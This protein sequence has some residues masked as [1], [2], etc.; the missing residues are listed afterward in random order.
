MNL[1]TRRPRFNLNA[2]LASKKKCG[3]HKRVW[4]TPR[5]TANA[6]LSNSAFY[7]KRRSEQL[8]TPLQT[9][10]WGTPHLTSN[11]SLSNFASCFKRKFEKLCVP[12]QTGVWE[13]LRLM[14]NASLSNSAYYFK[15]RSEQLCSPLQMQVWETPHLTSNA[16]LS[17]SA[18][19]LRRGFK[20]C[21]YT[22]ARSASSTRPVFLL[23]L[24]TLLGQL[25][26]HIMWELI[27]LWRNFKGQ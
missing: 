23:Q 10:A 8:C 24:T 14:S 9:R 5:Q 3:L 7:F 6:R 4:G 20:P 16:S 27:P 19:W 13:T 11:A 25:T 15:R 21:V 22:N 17:N 18:F 26:P 2:D 12:F 1:P